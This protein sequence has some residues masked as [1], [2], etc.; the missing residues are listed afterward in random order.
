MF[1]LLRQDSDTAGW[2]ALISS[3]HDMERVDMR[4]VDDDSSGDEDDNDASSDGDSSED[5]FS[6]DDI[7][8]DD[9]KLPRSIKLYPRLPLIMD[10]LLHWVSR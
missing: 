2:T 1:A 9:I 6:D 5:D 8:D 7:D 4:I 3:R 10:L